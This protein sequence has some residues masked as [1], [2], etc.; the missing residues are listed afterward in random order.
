MRLSCRTLPRN[1]LVRVPKQEAFLTLKHH[2]QPARALL[3]LLPTGDDTLPTDVINDRMVL[4]H[5]GQRSLET[6][7][8]RRPLRNDHQSPTRPRLSLRLFLLP[9]SLF[10]TLLLL[11]CFFP[12]PSGQPDYPTSFL[13]CCCLWRRL[14]PTQPDPARLIRVALSSLGRF[15]RGLTGPCLQRLLSFS[16]FPFAPF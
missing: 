15:K 5:P 3:R 9:L 6:I 8:N 11:E 13:L 4:V 12:L 7:C 16:P 1:K 10:L 2:H 14:W